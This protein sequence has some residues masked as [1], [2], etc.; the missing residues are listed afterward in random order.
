MGNTLPNVSKFAS[1]KSERSLS[2]F[3]NTKSEFT[4][5]MIKMQVDYCL[6]EQTKKTQKSVWFLFFLRDITNV[7]QLF[8]F[9]HG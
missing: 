9:H 6:H 2:K 7:I 8:F 5:N 4:K 3:R 1:H